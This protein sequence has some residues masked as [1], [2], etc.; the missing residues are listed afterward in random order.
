M[1]WL[2][3]SSL[4]IFEIIE[5]WLYRPRGRGFKPHRR[6]CIV[7]L[8]KNINPS[9]GLVQHRKTRPFIT[10]R[11]LM[12]RKESNQTNKTL[13]IPCLNIVNIFITIN[14]NI[15]FGCLRR[16]FETVLLS[17]HNLSPNCLTLK[18]FFAKVNFE[19]SQQTCQ[20]K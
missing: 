5:L 12:R 15:C 6:Y 16:F 20:T 19:E 4:F 3:A 11:L 10:K 7:F 13:V 14:L 8:S 2:Q 17:T 1:G 9:L 18:E